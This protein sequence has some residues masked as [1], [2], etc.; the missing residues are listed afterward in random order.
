MGTIDSFVQTPLL[1]SAAAGLVLFIL[2]LI[3]KIRKTAT[4]SFVYFPIIGI[5]VAGTLI[6]AF[7][8]KIFYL[9]IIFILIETLFIAYAFVLAVSDP[10]KVAEKHDLQ[11]FCI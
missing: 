8:P 2:L 11:Y 4:I 3:A 9:A 7:D 1:I 6:S 5:F 10:E